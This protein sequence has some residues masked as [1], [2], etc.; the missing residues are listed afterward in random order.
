MRV[1]FLTAIEV[2]F[3]CIS[4]N[5]C[6]TELQSQ[7]ENDCVLCCFSLIFFIRSLHFTLDLQMLVWYIMHEFSLNIS[8][9]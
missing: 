8:L 9:L 3:D 5:T 1:S 2:D 7:N 6:N 4:E